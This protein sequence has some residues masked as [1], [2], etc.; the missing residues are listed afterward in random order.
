[1]GQ[2]CVFCRV[3]N[4]QIPSSIVFED[5]ETLAFND[6]NPQAPVHII[7]MPKRHLERISDIDITNSQIMG[8]LV[9]VA[10]NLAALKG[11]LKS[12]YRIVINCN[13]DA[14]QAVFHLHVHLLGGR[15]LSWPPG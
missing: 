6:I 5:E 8:K 4:K 11:I 3:A 1:M 12:G 9:L 13:K 14:G 10:N 7:I 15:A 2:D